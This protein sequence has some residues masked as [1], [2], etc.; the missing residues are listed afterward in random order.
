MTPN[1]FRQQLA[2]SGIQ[3]SP[4]QVEQFHYYFQLLVEWNEKMNLTA[5][6]EEKEVYLKHFYDSISLAFFEDFAENKSL[7]DVGAGAGFPS[8]PL[9]I[10]FPSLQVTIVDSLN[11]R[12]TFLTEL[13]KALGLED[14]ALYHDRAETFGQ[15]PRFR[16]VFDYVTARAVARLNVLSELCLPLVKKEGF[17]LALKAAKSEEEIAEA[18]PA[19]ATLGGKFSKEI[20][21][22]LPIT[23]D[24]RHIVVIQKKKETPKKYPR[25]PGMPNKQPI[26]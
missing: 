21:F 22:E 13:V 11:K 26:K 7:C 12:I 20:A 24:E 16:G 25:K 18:K 15:Q 19:I 3:L 6:T 8:I 5:I 23:A 14:V 10:V 1:E 9:K 2:D 17:F 4:Q